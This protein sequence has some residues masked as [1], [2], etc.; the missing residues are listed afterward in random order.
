MVDID[1]DGGGLRRTDHFADTATHTAILHHRPHA[2][3][4]SQGL[5]CDGRA[6]RTLIGIAR[7]RLARLALGD[8]D[9]DGALAHAEVAEFQ[10]VGV[11]G[12]REGDGVGDTPHEVYNYAD[13]IWMD[14]PAAQFFKGTPMLETLDFLERLA[15]FSEPDLTLKDEEPMITLAALERR[16][17]EAEAARA[18]PEQPAESDEAASAYE[19]LRQSLG[20]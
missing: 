16:Q 13:R 4:V 7:R 10:V 3:P 19:R 5:Q 18:E 17:D 1:D 8:A 15:P 20:R 11:F 2:L 6:R 12:Y 9:L 14:V